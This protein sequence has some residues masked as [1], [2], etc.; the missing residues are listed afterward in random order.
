MRNRFMVTTVFTI[1]LSGILMSCSFAKQEVVSEKAPIQLATIKDS[2]DRACLENYMDMYLD[3][4]KDNNP[5]LDLFTR[6][7]KFTENGIQ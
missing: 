2:C 6:D 7:C 1:L 5:S 3:A 4:M